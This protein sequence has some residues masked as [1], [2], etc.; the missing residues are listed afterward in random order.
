MLIFLTCLFI[1]EILIASYILKYFINTFFSFVVA[2]IAE[3]VST[4][5]PNTISARPREARPR[6]QPLLFIPQP[7]PQDSPELKAHM[8][9]IALK[10]GI[11]TIDGK[12]SISLLIIPVINI[13]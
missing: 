8:K 4:G 6:I 10:N 3:A 7:R 13:S 9:Q 5:R 12:V 2:S 1:V 11:L